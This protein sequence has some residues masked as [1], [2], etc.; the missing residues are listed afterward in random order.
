MARQSSVLSFSLF[1]FLLLVLICGAALSCED[2][3]DVPGHCRHHAIRRNRCHKEKSNKKTKGISQD[4][5]NQ[6]RLMAQYSA[7]AYR[8]GNTNSTDTPITCSEEHCKYRPEGN[9]PLVEKAKATTTVEF[10]DTPHFDD[11]GRLP[12]PTRTMALTPMAGFIAVDPT[13]KLVV[14]SFRGS[15][16]HQNWLTDIDL[17]K[18]C[19]NLCDTCYVHDGFWKS[20]T[21]L[22]DMIVPNV[23]K[24]TEAH[25]DYRFIVT[26][27]SLGAAIA[28]L[29]AADLRKLNP[30]F[31]EHTELFSF[32]SPRVGDVGTA[33]FL[34]KQSKKSY[35]ITAGA[36]PIPR[37]PGPI[38]GY[39]HMSPEYWI[40][41]KPWDPKPQ[42]VF[43]ITGY[44]NRDGNTGTDFR[45][46][47]DHRKYFGYIT[48]CDPDP[49]ED[50]DKKSWVRFLVEGII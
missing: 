6:F 18:V 41:H 44:Y 7:A 8:P 24:A 43:I 28:T 14:L 42:D 32:G 37:V 2:V 26:G 12:C 45:T 16:S 10:E 17:N 11:H 21:D 34:T 1:T 5:L 29:A 19:S 15:H 27:H 39:M 25:P 46:M 35:R 23:M 30:W 47:E 49:P 48:K 3:D 40:A 36:D 31:M 4:L 38:L 22:R 13:N 50:P 33:D 9:C 20:W